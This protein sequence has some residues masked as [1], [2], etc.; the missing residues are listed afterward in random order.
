MNANAF[1]SS[2]ATHGLSDLAQQ[3]F[4]RLEGR[5]LLLADWMRAVFIHYEV[6]PAALKPFVPLDTRNGNA[7][8][9]LVAFTMEDLRLNPA[10]R[11]GVWLTMPVATHGLLNVRTYV[12]HRDEPGIYF[13]KEWIPNRLSVLLGPLTYG[14]PYRLGRLDYRHDH[15]RGTLAGSVMPAHDPGRLNYHAALPTRVRWRSAQT[16]SL[17]A[18]LLERY[19]AYTLRGREICRFRIW[20]EPWMLAPINVT[21][22][23]ESAIRAAGAWH[24]AAHLAIA[25]YSPGVRNVWIGPPRRIA[26]RH[27]PQYN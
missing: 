6:P 7:Y 24:D 22:E 16:D 26:H 8:V 13:L 25:H 12:T 14:L 23:D 5:P 1:R 21:L 10:G 3:R 11:L 27:E 20:H 15:V 17:A 9:S 2:P 19:T 4:R 18:F